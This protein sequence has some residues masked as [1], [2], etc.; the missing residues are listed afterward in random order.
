MQ[1]TAD[2]YNVLV[3][4]FICSPGSPDTTTPLG[5]FTIN[6]KPGQWHP[7][8]GKTYGQWSIRFNNDILF[9]SVPYRANNPA[10]LVTEEYDKLG[11]AVS[12]GC[13]RMRVSDVKWLYDNCPYGTS[14]IV[15]SDANEPRPADCTAAMRISQLDSPFSDWD[16][17]DPN[18]EN[19]WHAY[20][21]DEPEMT[22][23]E[24]NLEPEE[25]EDESSEENDMEE[26]TEETETQENGEGTDD[27][28]E[29]S[30]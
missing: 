2:N 5:S 29:P 1:S 6:Q 10:T 18:P 11:Q 15:Y 12:A 14:V 7:L 3:K 23:V 25:T 13:V 9:H 16:P 21:P 19:P 22:V 28:E 8:Y 17:T 20:A 27:A 4:S 26:N 30:D 24:S